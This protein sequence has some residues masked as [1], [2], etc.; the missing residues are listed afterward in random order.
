[1]K[2]FSKRNVF[3]LIL[4][5]CML[6][7]Q[8]VKAAEEVYYTNPNNVSFTKEQYDFFTAMY[9]EGYQEIVTPELFA[10]FEED[11]MM[12][13]LVESKTYVDYDIPSTRATVVTSNSKSLK[14]AKGGSSRCSVS[15]VLNWTGSPTIRSYD[16]IG[17][18][19]PSVTLIGTP[20]TTSSAGS[21]TTIENDLRNTSTG[22]G[23]S[24]KLP[25]QDYIKIAQT[26]MTTTGGRVYASYQHAM[27]NVTQSDSRNYSVGY[28][29]L[30]HVF[31][32][33]SNTRGYYDG[34]EGV[35][36]DC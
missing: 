21:T 5:M 25:S 16:V 31:D 36:I 14:I 15:V 20:Y 28:A 10:M 30:G 23:V 24:I 17:A 6:G 29:G 13:D 8:N 34:M 35:Y 9:Y 3:L 4:S 7:V 18:Y 22:F 1:M 32:F 27:V 19:L 2:L 11:E 12:A 26:Y 33:V